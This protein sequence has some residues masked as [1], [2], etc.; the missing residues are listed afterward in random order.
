VKMKISNGKIMTTPRTRVLEDAEMAWIEG[1]MAGLGLSA[2]GVAILAALTL[3][4][5]HLR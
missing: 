4:I 3:L 2:C 1:L 5:Y